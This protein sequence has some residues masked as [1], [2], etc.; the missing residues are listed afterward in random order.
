MVQRKVDMGR[1]ESW[2]SLLLRSKKQ[3]E[4]RFIGKARNKGN[5]KEKTNDKFKECVPHL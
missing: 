4:Q 5:L 2:Q 3:T 1:P